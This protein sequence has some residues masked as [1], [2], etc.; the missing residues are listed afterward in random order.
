MRLHRSLP[1]MAVV[2]VFVATLFGQQS[3][4]KSTQGRLAAFTRVEVLTPGDFIILLSQAKSGDREAQ[5]LLALVYRRGLLVTRDLAVAK[6]WM[7][8]SAEQG[9]GPAQGGMAEMYLPNLC[10]DVPNPDYREAE[11]WLR[12]AAA[13]GDADAQFWLGTGYEQSW[14]GAADYLE[15]LKWLRKAAQQGHPD[16][17][18][19]LG[20][21]YE[22]GEGVPANDVIAAHWYREAADH[23]PSYLGGVWEAETQL[24]YMYRDRRLPRDDVQAY[25]WFSIVGSSVEPPDDGDIKKVARHMTKEQIAEAQSLA[26]DWVKRHTP[27]RELSRK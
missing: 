11:G 22:D 7:L 15:A 1:P 27:N 23:S 21:M 17:Q 8:K 12:L 16:A 13:Q 18:F 9:Y 25:M 5:Y 10:E 14:F 20:Q 19:C 2:I 6:S 4:P 3:L 24:V 26:E